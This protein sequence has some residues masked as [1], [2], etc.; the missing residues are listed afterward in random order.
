MALADDLYT[1]GLKI[2]QLKTLR[3]DKE[4]SVTNKENRL[5]IYFILDIDGN[6][7]VYDTVA[8]C[9]AILEATRLQ[10][11]SEDSE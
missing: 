7:V 11:V 9:T 1:I 3:P 6:R 2:D 10:Y 5:G 4:F 8:E